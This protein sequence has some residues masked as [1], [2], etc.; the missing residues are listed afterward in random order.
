MQKGRTWDGSCPP[1]TW[2]DSPTVLT[3]T[4]LSKSQFTCASP[5]WIESI[6][7]M[8][9]AKVTAQ[10]QERLL[11]IVHHMLLGVLTLYMKH[12]SIMRSLAY[13]Y[14]MPVLDKATAHAV[15]RQ[16]TSSAMS[17]QISAVGAGNSGPGI[18]KAEVYRA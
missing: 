4:W 14:A 5:A 17:S 2:N 8:R 13:V 12:H 9:L 1:L 6:C 15:A 16:R 10:D 7:C 18:W 3:A 11:L